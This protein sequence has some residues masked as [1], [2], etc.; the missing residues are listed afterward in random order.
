MPLLVDVNGV[1]VDVPVIAGVSHEPVLPVMV[2]LYAV[3]F[4]CCRCDLTCGC[5][6]IMNN[7]Y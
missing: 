3:V 1:Q 5:Y 7:M 6:N 2:P 4:A